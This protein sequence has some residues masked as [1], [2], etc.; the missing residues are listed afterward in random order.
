MTDFLPVA[1]ESFRLIKMPDSIFYIIA[2]GGAGSLGS[3]A[4][5]SGR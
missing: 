5:V 4:L 3:P 1:E 2:V